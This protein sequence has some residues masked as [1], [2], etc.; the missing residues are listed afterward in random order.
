MPSASRMEDLALSVDDENGQA[1][2]GILSTFRYPALKNAQIV[3]YSLTK[4]AL[5]FDSSYRF[6]TLAGARVKNENLVHE[7]FIPVSQKGFMLLKEYGRSNDSPDVGA[8]VNDQWDI[9]TLFISNAIS[10]S[11]VTPPITRDGYTRYDRLGGMRSLYARGDLNLFYLPA[12]STDSCWSGIIN[13][14]QLTEL[15]SPFLSYLVVPDKGRIYFLYNSFFGKEEQFG[16]TT[17]LDQHGNLQQSGALVFWKFNITLDFQQSRQI[18]QN[19]VA[20]P[21]ANYHRSGF[22]IIRF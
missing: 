8:A 19:E 9:E 2:A 4:Q 16:S 7:R 14:E 12:Q 17:V 5:E 1:I 6:S 15:N 13:K 3:H 10:S 18:A 21:Y 20:V 22:A 11:W